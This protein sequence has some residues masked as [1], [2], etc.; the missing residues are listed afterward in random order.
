MI[1][2]LSV[3]FCLLFVI[4]IKFDHVSLAYQEY[5]KPNEAE[6]QYRYNKFKAMAEKTTTVTLYLPESINTIDFGDQTINYEYSAL[7]NAPV[8]GSPAL[9]AVGTTPAGYLDAQEKKTDSHGNEQYKYLGFTVLGDI[10]INPYYPENIMTTAIS[11]ITWMKEPWIATSSHPVYPPP[12]SYNY[13]SQ[14]AQIAEGTERAQIYSPFYDSKTQKTYIGYIVCIQSLKDSLFE[15]L[16]N[17]KN[18]FPASNIEASSFYKNIESMQDYFAIISPRTEYTPLIAVGRMNSQN[19]YGIYTLPPLSSY[20]DLSIRFTSMGVTSADDIKETKTYTG[21]V[22]VELQDETNFAPKE[23]IPLKIYYTR[24]NDQISIPTQFITPTDL[25]VTNHAANASR[26]AKEF[27]FDWTAGPGDVI[28]LRAEINSPIADQRVINESLYDNN[29]T[30]SSFSFPNPNMLVGGPLTYK[31]IVPNYDPFKKENLIR[32]NL[33][34]YDEENKTYTK[35]YTGFVENDKD[36]LFSYKTNLITMETSPYVTAIAIELSGRDTDKEKPKNKYVF[37]I[38]P[39]TSAGDRGI[40][41]FRVKKEPATKSL[42][43]FS[44]TDYYEPVDLFG[45]CFLSQIKPVVLRGQTTTTTEERKLIW[46]VHLDL[47]NNIFSKTLPNET[48]L[49]TLTFTAFDFKGEWKK[50][51]EVNPLTFFTN[52]RPAKLFNFRISDVKDIYWKSVFNTSSGTPKQYKN[53]K[54]QYK[55]EPPFGVKKLPLKTN[56]VSSNRYISKGYAVQCKIDSEGFY[57]NSSVLVVVP[58]F[59][60]YGSSPTSSM[61]KF[62]QVDLYYDVPDNKFI[63]NPNDRTDSNLYRSYQSSPLYNVP[64]ETES[65]NTEDPTKD[66]SNLTNKVL[67]HFKDNG[68]DSNYL[69]YLTKLYQ[70]YKYMGSTYGKLIISPQLKKFENKIVMQGR[71]K[72]EFAD[73]DIP[74]NQLT[75]ING[76]NYYKDFKNY[77]NTWTFSYSIHPK[78]KAFLKGTNY[79]PFKTRPLTGPILVNF[80]IIGYSSNKDSEIYNYT[81]LESWASN[82]TFKDVFIKNS[83]DTYEVKPYNGN[84]FYFNLDHSALDDYSTQQKW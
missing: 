25:P 49:E 48:V 22:L 8:Y 41:T 81:N 50:A 4:L 82:P 61:K 79:D 30:E 26:P 69:K 68:A 52:I 5:T 24:N 46:K 11:D 43:L 80:K 66:K 39:W 14:Y 29:I 77:R 62:R 6:Y 19:K 75:I 21:K 34:D 9:W 74:E 42:E 15:I 78:T 73:N 55:N 72:W 18:L 16:K 12:P 27:S 63:R 32:I 2:K 64:I 37:L 71:D 53:L 83:D 33:E 20:P 57:D 54:D 47:T 51:H 44:N 31:S 67:E 23:S 36:R 35:K 1:K 10:F 58:T 17:E 40:D 84:V 70:Y 59:W 38:R 3:L 76:D 45:Y 60:W 28:Y 13:W 56:P 7:Y 65:I